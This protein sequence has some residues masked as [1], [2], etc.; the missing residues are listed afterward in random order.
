MNIPLSKLEES[1]RSLTQITPE[2]CSQ[3]NDVMSIKDLDPNYD[4]IVSTVDNDSY[5]KF[6]CVT[7]SH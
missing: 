4:G 7:E 5:C 6:T 2:K 1:E 3:C